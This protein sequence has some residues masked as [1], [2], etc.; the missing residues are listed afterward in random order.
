MSSPYTCPSCKTNR[1]RFHIIE[2][3]PKA[4]KLDPNNGDVVETYETN[5]LEP[6]HLPY[7]GPTIKVQCGACGLI[8]NE[9]RFVKQAKM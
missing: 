7:Q 6:F 5:Q 3:V 9:E 4:V 8:E 1:S 2:Q